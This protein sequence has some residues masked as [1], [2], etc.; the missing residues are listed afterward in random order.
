MLDLVELGEVL[1]HVVVHHQGDA[2]MAAIEADPNR[3]RCRRRQLLRRS[4]EAEALQALE[5]SPARQHGCVRDE[6][7]GEPGGAKRGDRLTRPRHRLVLDV[8]HAVEVEQNGVD[9][10]SRA[11]S[12]SDAPKRSVI[13]GAERSCADS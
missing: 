5:D 4:G 13:A 7:D 2:L 8:E 6:A 10:H 12:G 11:I 3:E 9:S 1:L